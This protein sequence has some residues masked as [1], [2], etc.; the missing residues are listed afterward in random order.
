MC[1]VFF[2]DDEADLRLAIEQTFELAD[3]HAKF[4]VD[5][6]SALIA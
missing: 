1:Q 5:A 2:I 6:E 3:I 4:F